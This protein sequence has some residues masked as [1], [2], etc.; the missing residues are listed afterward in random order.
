MQDQQIDTVVVAADEQLGTLQPMLQANH[1]YSIQIAQDRHASI[2]YIAIYEKQKHAI[3]YIAPVRS[4]APWP[5]EPRKFEVKFAAPAQPIGPIKH[6]PG[7]KV[8]PPQGRRYAN[9]DKIM[10]A[11][12]LDDVWT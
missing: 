3:T 2:Q 9:R 10:Q 12:N 5:S 4:I 6:V 7:S 11:Q 1:W 8:K